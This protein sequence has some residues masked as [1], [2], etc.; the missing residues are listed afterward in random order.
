[1]I[2]RGFTIEVK[3]RIID[4]VDKREVSV[5]DLDFGRVVSPDERDKAMLECIG[6]IDAWLD[7]Y[8]I[9]ANGPTPKPTKKSDAKPKSTAKRGK[10]VPGSPGGAAST[11]E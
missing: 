1:M 4:S 7:A 3:K 11:P 6:A 8:K 9:D 5:P 10:R 2:Y